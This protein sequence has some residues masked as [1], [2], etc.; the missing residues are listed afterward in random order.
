MNEQ[1]YEDIALEKSL[2]ANFGVEADINSVIARRMPVGRTGDGTLFLT[3]K[4]QLYFYIDSP[5]RLLLSDIQKIVSRAGLKAELYFPP[6]GQPDYFDE[7][8]RQ[9]FRE[10]FP[11]RRDISSADIVFYRTLA[12]YTPALVLI[13]E[14]KTGVVYQYDSDSTG[15]WRPNTKFTYRRIKTS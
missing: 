7:I 3:K 14:V 12:P 11:G 1:V 10:I 13:S 2:R 8:G 15:G 6:R 9:K 5:H 4:K